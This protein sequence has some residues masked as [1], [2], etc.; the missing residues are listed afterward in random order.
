MPNDDIYS[1][2]ISKKELNYESSFVNQ[3]AHQ[4]WCLYRQDMKI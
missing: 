1:Y 4:T 2:Y 3:Y